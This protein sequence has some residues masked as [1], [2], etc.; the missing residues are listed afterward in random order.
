MTSAAADTRPPLSPVPQQQPGR[1]KSLLFTAGIVALPVVYVLTVYLD[2][3]VWLFTATRAVLVAVAISVSLMG[4]ASILLRS[5]VHGSL[6][7]LCLVGMLVVHD[8]PRLVV[9][10]GIVAVSVAVL[11][12]AGPRAPARLSRSTWA[13]R[14]LI[15]AFGLVLLV[16]TIAQFGLRGQAIASGTRWSGAA[17][18]GVAADSGAPDIWLVLLDG[19]PRADVLE[20]HWDYSNPGFVRGL[21]GLGFDVADE[22]RSNYNLTAHTLPALL[23][24]AL[25]E[26]LEPWSSYDKPADAPAA[27]RIRALQDNRAFETLRDHGYH[28][29]SI[30]AGYTTADVRAVDDY[31]D[32][33]TAD[34]FEMHLL[35]ETALGGLV[36]TIYPEF[37][38]AQVRQRIEANLETLSRMAE[39]SSDKPRF[40]FGHIPGPHAPYVYASVERPTVAL[41]DIFHAPME[42]YG[43]D[44]LKEAYAEH[45]AEFDDRVLLTLDTMVEAIGDEAVIIVMSDHGSR[46]TGHG[47]SLSPAEADEQFSTLLA[48]RTP[49]GE[50]LFDEDITTTNVLS[51]VLNRYLGTEIES[52]DR[53]FQSEDGTRYVE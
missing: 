53:V 2:Q 14:N 48:V 44:L 31:V 20:R 52:A 6:V 29:T 45:I 38:D 49:D 37:G 51:G 50:K 40:V 8:V 25:L 28:L 18:A 41:L 19:H 12:L 46:M 43:I 16:V 47:H 11:A 36:Q 5:L 33:G 15:G 9:A 39:E 32:A 21:E 22:S 30:S 26:D 35:G 34:V 42:Q 24:M 3:G 13:L 23:N 7:G 1:A 17:A 27:D 10:L 4:V